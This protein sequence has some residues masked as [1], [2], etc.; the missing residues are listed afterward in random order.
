MSI[1]SIGTTNQGVYNVSTYSNQAKNTNATLRDLRKQYSNLNLSAQSFSG[2]GAIRS[3]AEGQSGKYNVAIDPRAITRMGTDSKF[4]DKIHAD[5]SD[6]QR[7]HDAL[8]QLINRGP[9]G[10]TTK[11]VACG[12]VIDKDGNSGMWVRTEST[13]QSSDDGLFASSSKS[14]QDLLERLEKKR[15]EKMAEARKLEKDQAVENALEDETTTQDTVRAR[16]NIIV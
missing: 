5:L 16:L 14:Q 2:E 6:V 8:E 3:Y 13:A 1:K 12:T 7:S 9:N 15:Q 4:A 10:S 11:M